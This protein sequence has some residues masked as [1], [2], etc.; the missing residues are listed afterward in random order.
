M[1]RMTM[2]VGVGC[3]CVVIYLL[4][5]LLGPSVHAG[6]LTVQMV[7]PVGTAHAGKLAKQVQAGLRVL[8]VPTI[9][10]AFINQVLAAY[11]SPARGTGQAL[12]AL[13]VRYGIDPVVALAF[14]MHESRFGT[15]GEARFSKSLGNLRCIAGALC[16]ENYAWFPTWQAGYQAWYVLIRQVYVEQWGCV[17]VEQIIPHYAP[18]AD[19]NDETAYIAAVEQAVQTWRSGQVWV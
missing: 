13:G 19:G 3:A 17:T 18:S 16:R 4:A 8:G 1:R 14:F 7:R 12:Y 11:Q 6:V 2:V 10:A 5:G 9:S 15:Q